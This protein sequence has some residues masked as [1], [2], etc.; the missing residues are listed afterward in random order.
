[1]ARPPS[2]AAG[3]T[4]LEILVALAVLG[5]VMVG[6][7]QG[8]RYGLQAWNTQERLAAERD[9]LDA[10]DRALRQLVSHIEADESRKAS[11]LAGEPH[12]FAFTTTLPSVVA[13]TTRRADVTLMVDKRHRLVLRWTPHLHEMMLGAPPRAS[14]VELL[15]GMERVVFSYWRGVGA[16]GAPAGWQPVW[17]DP[18]PPEVVRIHLVFTKDDGRHW[19]DIIVS[20]VLEATTG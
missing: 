19:P 7:T 14:E 17:A 4:L 5:L 6:L 2:P 1:M 20:H 16:N 10:T 18:V 3:F 13:L 12:S 15:S 11:W 9:Q 8:F